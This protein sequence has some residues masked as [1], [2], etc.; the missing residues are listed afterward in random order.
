MPSNVGV[1]AIVELKAI[2]MPP[3]K[4]PPFHSGHCEIQIRPLRLNR[5][6]RYWPK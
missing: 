3:E 4:G 5:G 2:L 6:A 1:R